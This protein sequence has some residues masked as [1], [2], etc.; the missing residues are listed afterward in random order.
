MKQLKVIFWDFDGTMVDSPLPDPGKQ[1]WG[2]HHG[3]PYPHVGWWGRVESL[4]CDVFDVQARGHVLDEYKKH[5]GPGCRNYILTSRQPKFESIIQKILDKNGI[6]MDG[7]MTAKGSFT[8]G[9]RIVQ[10]IK[11]FAAQDYQ[12]TEVH[13][14]DDRLKE[15]N[16]VEA[17]RAEI[18]GLG[19]E[20]TVHKIESDAQD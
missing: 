20:L 3:K 19:V 9:D 11:E 12:V 1:M 2:K 8:K 6:H 17:V 16:A 7:I 10:A 15:I 14:Y 13:F 5:S 18:E 4:D